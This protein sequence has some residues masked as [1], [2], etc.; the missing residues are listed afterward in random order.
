MKSRCGILAM[1]EMFDSLLETTGCAIPIGRD[2]W[3]D[4]D[5]RIR[6]V[7]IKS[8]HLLLLRWVS[9]AAKAGTT[10][11][12]PSPSLHQRGRRSATT[13]PPPAG[14]LLSIFPPSF[15]THDSSQRHHFLQWLFVI[16]CPDAPTPA[17]RPR[18]SFSTSDPNRN[19]LLFGLEHKRS[20]IVN[21]R[22]RHLQDLA[23]LSKQRS[24]F[25]ELF[26]SCS[27]PASH[28][29]LRPSSDSEQQ[30]SSSMEEITKEFEERKIE[31][32]A[33]ALKIYQASDADIKICITCQS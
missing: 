8:T 31:L 28:R 17:S 23:A 5:R 6:F 21:I 19:P 27:A 18:Q 4:E 32:E 30:A 11:L 29:H 26:T 25:G 9:H 16:F 1:V 33:K 7:E 3:I 14:H 22:P 15:S 10:L 12:P 24:S 20:F 13:P 2:I